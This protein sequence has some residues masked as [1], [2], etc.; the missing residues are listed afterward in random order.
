MRRMLLGSLL[1]AGLVLAGGPAAGKPHEPKNKPNGPGGLSTD[2]FTCA[3]IQTA[4]SRFFRPSATSK[5]RLAT[6][7]TTLTAS[8]PEFTYTVYVYDDAEPGAALVTS[9]SV[10][11]NGSTNVTFPEVY[12]RQ[13]PGDTTI[14][15]VVASGDGKTVY[16]REPDAG[17]AFRDL[18]DGDPVEWGWFP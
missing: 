4:G 5:P 6:H 7:L 14:C 1:A 8:C 18:N 17:C 9:I 12:I 3:D 10:A 15:L 2:Y 11:G 16:D 13:E